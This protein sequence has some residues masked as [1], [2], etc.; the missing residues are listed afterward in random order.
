MPMHLKRICSAIDELA[1]DVDFGVSEQLDSQVSD[2]PQHLSQRSEADS[3][4]TIEQNDSQA[5]LVMSQEA[6]PNTS[7]SKAKVQK[8]KARS[9][10]MT[11]FS[12]EMC[13]MYV[14]AKARGRGAREAKAASY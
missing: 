13:Y 14:V 7:F 3:L 5:S 10:G 12:L 6:T 2:D 1:P 8:A 11:M 9:K 4:S